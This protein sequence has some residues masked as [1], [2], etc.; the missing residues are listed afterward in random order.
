MSTVPFTIRPA[1]PADAV[2]V[3]RLNAGLFAEDSARHDPA[4][5]QG[6][7][8]REGA[9]YFAELLG[10]D[11]AAGWLALR[12]D[13]PIGYAVGRLGGPHDLRP[14]PGP[15]WRASSSSRTAVATGWAPPSWLSSRGGRPAGV[16][17]SSP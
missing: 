2:V 13:T 12:G 4:V 7:P 5:D 14:V 3:A 15:T 16:P 17:R 11:R 6:W 8:A 1:T 10:S 9:R